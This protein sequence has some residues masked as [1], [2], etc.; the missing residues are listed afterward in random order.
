MV[1]VVTEA[2]EGFKVTSDVSEGKAGGLRVELD[3]DATEAVF[4]EKLVVSDV[5]RIGRG[6]SEVG[7][8]VETG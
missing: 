5:I 8:V 7:I 1:G 2:R 6:G 3:S 4:D